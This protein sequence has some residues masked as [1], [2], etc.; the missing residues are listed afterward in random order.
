MSHELRT[1]LNAILDFTPIMQ[2][3]KSATR[4]QLENLAV[5]NRSGEHLLA[6]IGGKS[7]R[8]I[9]RM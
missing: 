1:P 6:L 2:R 7:D 5:V 8:F 4:S 3:D 9:D